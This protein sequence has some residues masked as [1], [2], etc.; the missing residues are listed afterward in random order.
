MQRR[1]LRA[2]CDSRCFS[3]RSLKRRE[4]SWPSC[5][6][7]VFQGEREGRENTTK[8]LR[9]Y[10]HRFV[11]NRE[12][13]DVDG[14]GVEGCGCLI[15]GAAVARLTQKRERCRCGFDLWC[16]KCGFWFPRNTYSKVTRMRRCN[17]VGT[18][19][20]GGGGGSS[21]LDCGRESWLPMCANPSPR[22]YP[23]V[24]TTFPVQ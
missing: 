4:V 10:V 14:G 9:L 11:L 13:L 18:S 24:T 5:Y 15:L 16:T 2:S 23:T 7:R 22:T 19:W 17:D 20:G 3:L 12:T 1:C 8:S 21:S 6:G